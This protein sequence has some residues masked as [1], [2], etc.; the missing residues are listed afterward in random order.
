MSKISSLENCHNGREWVQTKK[1]VWHKAGAHCR[2]LG[3]ETPFMAVKVSIQPPQ[4]ICKLCQKD[5]AK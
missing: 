2:G 3:K 1:G 5:P 4:P